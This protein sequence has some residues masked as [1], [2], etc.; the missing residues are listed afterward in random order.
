MRIT[1]TMSPLVGAPLLL[2]LGL[3]VMGAPMGDSKNIYIDAGGRNGDTLRL[4][5]NPPMKKDARNVKTVAFKQELNPPG[6]DT[7]SY[8]VV[9]F[10]ALPDWCETIKAT[11]E[12]GL[13][14]RGWKG[15]PSFQLN[16]PMAVWDSNTTLTF[17]KDPSPKTKHAG[18]SAFKTWFHKE[19][20]MQIPAI[21]F[22][23][24][25]GENVQ[26]DDFCLVK[27]DIEAAEY[28]VLFRMLQM[29]TLKLVDKLV[30]EWHCEGKENDKKKCGGLMPAQRKRLMRG[31]N[32]V[33]RDTGH[34]LV[35][36]H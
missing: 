24:W 26:Q 35:T 6:R 10:E 4:F 27:M 21:D 36:W 16:C 13:A 34:Q 23:T 22:S 2:V 3:V 12:K 32:K 14:E 28:P 7:S 29:G 1:I 19:A 9:I 18:S 30:I 25:I 11:H 20:P 17:Y 8:H 5:A 15:F 33:F 31:I